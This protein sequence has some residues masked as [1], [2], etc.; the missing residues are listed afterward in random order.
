MLMQQYE[1]PTITEASASVGGF[2][3]LDPQFGMRQ[4]ARPV[5]DH[6]AVGADDRTSP[7]F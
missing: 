2:A 6:L 4:P 5:A 7:P 3:Q 1:Q